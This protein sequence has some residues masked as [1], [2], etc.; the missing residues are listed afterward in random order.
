MKSNRLCIF[1]ACA[2]ACLSARGIVLTV[3]DSSDAGDLSLA[4]SKAVAT[5]CVETNQRWQDD[6]LCN[7]ALTS[8]IPSLTRPRLHT[9]TIWMVDPGVVLDSVFAGNGGV[10]DWGYADPVEL[11]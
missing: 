8:S 4:G 10:T 5:I 3:A 1:L 7:A 2:C 11:R 6:V 9:L